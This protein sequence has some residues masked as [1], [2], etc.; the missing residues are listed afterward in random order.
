MR[1]F[2]EVSRVLRDLW[3]ARLMFDRL[4]EQTT[5]W[6]TRNRLAHTS[7]IGDNSRQA[8]L[9]RRE[10]RQWMRNP[11]T[12]FPVETRPCFLEAEW[13]AHPAVWQRLVVGLPHRGYRRRIQPRFAACILLIYSSWGDLK[14][15]KE[16]IG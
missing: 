14:D 15:A 11:K 13:P 10:H 2:V 1:T 7:I 5:A 8:L 16:M 4:R 3:R 12:I 6:R 9:R